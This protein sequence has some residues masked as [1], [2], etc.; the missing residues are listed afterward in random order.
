MK[1]NKK[2]FLMLVENR[3]KYNN[4]FIFIFHEKLY[5]N[6]LTVVN[7]NFFL[8]YILFHY[9]F[10]RLLYLQVNQFVYIKKRKTSYCC[11]F[12]QF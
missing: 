7:I 11:I 6:C 1:K 2:K 3:T 12:H 9:N 4:R 8:N 5:F 10:T